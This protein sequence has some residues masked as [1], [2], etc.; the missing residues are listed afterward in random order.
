MKK[1]VLLLFLSLVVIYVSFLI[2]NSK[3]SEIQEWE[4]EQQIPNL[5]NK[6]IE[7]WG[8]KSLN[9]KH[10]KVY[11][12]QIKIAIIDSGIDKSHQ[13]LKG[14]VTKEFNAIKPNESIVDDTG[15]GTGIAGIIGARNNGTGTR[16]VVGSSRLEIYSIKAFEKG[17]SNI[18]VIERALRWAIDQNVDIINFSA[19]T[20][21]ASVEL[22]NLI[23][24]AVNKKIITISAAGNSF[25]NH[26]QFPANQPNVIS[27][28][29]VNHEYNQVSGTTIK[30]VDIV[31]PGLDILTTFPKNRFNYLSHT[32]SAT[33]FV[34]GIVSN[35]LSQNSNRYKMK[36]DEIL[37]V[38]EE[39]AK[40]I[41]LSNGSKYYF[42]QESYR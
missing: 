13:E 11:K 12:R 9:I 32:S 42:V 1:F 16:G 10:E 5:T 19:G 30:N 27:V 33:A 38:L 20:S 17:T 23:V 7:S 35:L 15:H 31:G 29:A 18:K 40:V 2:V 36:H 21:K 22:E 14:I 25:N 3:S 41:K 39:N 37:N 4:K 8:Y 34:T 24:E 28:G 6:Q 26:I